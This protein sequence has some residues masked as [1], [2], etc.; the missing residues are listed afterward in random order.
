MFCIPELPPAYLAYSSVIVSRRTHRG[1][2]PPPFLPQLCRLLVALPP[3]RTRPD[4]DPGIHRPQ[5]LLR[6]L[7]LSRS[8]RPRSP[9]TIVDWDPSRTGFDPFFLFG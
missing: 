6:P 3:R 1:Q 9:R 2:R 8:R 5:L 4:P 7:S